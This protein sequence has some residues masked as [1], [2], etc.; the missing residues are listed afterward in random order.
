MATP[1]PQ[2]VALYTQLAIRV[3]KLIGSLFKDKDYPFASV[4]INVRNGRARITSV[5]VLDGASQA[6]WRALGN[7]LVN[8]INNHLDAI[9]YLDNPGIY[10]GNVYIGQASG[11]TGSLLGTGYF[12]GKTGGG[13]STGADSTGIPTIQ[14]AIAIFFE[15]M[16][17]QIRGLPN[18]V[19]LIQ[20]DDAIQPT[21]EQNQLAVDDAL[22]RSQ[23]I[24]DAALIENQRV[25]NSAV[26]SLTSSNAGF[27]DG[28]L[29]VVTGGLNTLLGVSDDLL[30]SAIGQIVVLTDNSILNTERATLDN[31]DRVGG[32]AEAAILAEN[33]L[34]QAFTLR[35]IEVLDTIEDTGQKTEAT[36]SR[37]LAAIL[38]EILEANEQIR[39]DTLGKIYDTIEGIAQVIVDR[40]PTADEAIGGGAEV[41]ADVLRSIRD[42]VIP[43]EMSR[44]LENVKDT[45]QVV[46]DEI[47]KIIAQDPN[48]VDKLEEWIFNA[49]TALQLDQATCKE[50]FTKPAN[51]ED[52]S[53]NFIYLVANAISALMLP[54]VIAQAR[55]Q[56]CLQQ[57]AKTHPYVELQPADAALAHFRGLISKDRALENIRAAGFA[58][59]E[60]EILLE[61]AKELPDLNTLIA[62]WL[63]NILPE[64]EL[65]KAILGHGFDATWLPRLKEV[66]FFIPPVQDLIT[67]AV[68]EVFDPVIAASFGQFD[69]FPDE[70]A[71]WAKQQGVSDEWAMNYWAAHWALPSIQ[72]GFEMLHRRVI[73]ET[74]LKQLMVALDIM[75]G[76]RDE[77]IQISYNP[78]TRVDI[79][80][81]HKVGVL[82][83]EDVYEAYLDLGY[84]ETNARKL[85]EFVDK[86]NDEDETLQEELADELTRSN[87]IGFY[88]DGI[89]DRSTAQAL[90]L[91][92]GYNI[93]SVAL[94]LDDADFKQERADRKADINIILEQ[95]KIGNISIEE[96]RS[97]LDTL[98][99][100]TAER[101]KA[102][103][104]LQRVI[105]A[106]VKMP[107]KT[108]LDKMLAAGIISDSEYQTNMARLGYSDYWIDK[109]RQ[110]AQSK[111]T[112]AN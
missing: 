52:L 43:V 62:M 108:D 48:E 8:D 90:M 21:I 97:Q 2:T 38:N 87:I 66:A 50:R 88:S 1:D 71:F 40:I 96:A 25:I 82:T 112:N 109:Y 85:Q 63:R 36:Y 59:Q 91:N 41:I 7:T 76:W 55:A 79:R 9:G 94:F 54:L 61:T 31:L 27:L 95:A 18:D 34:H 32:I 44:E 67:M 56:G 37:I 47:T 105:Q 73:D 46:I 35:A 15:Y 65:T 45:T 98:G 64:A 13:F 16:D 51:P 11:R 86:L 4:W 30:E 83:S 5:N 28:A 75:P 110:L 68:R 12:T 39:T 33:N 10:S 111:V 107:S 77:L 60:D 19:T 103:V 74:K 42:K 49:A 20:D 102:L 72:M 101:D 29:D 84:N 78:F 100:E 24:I 17:E 92:A 14:Q 89:I 57:W 26:S 99:L 6:K 3:G 22:A 58:A 106:N 53:G 80:R 104:Q 81:M 23:E 69:E 93:I 70:F